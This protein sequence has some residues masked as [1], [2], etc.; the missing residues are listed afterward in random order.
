MKEV[1]ERL[2]I[3]RRLQTQ[4]VTKTHSIRP[5]YFYGGPSVPVPSDEMG[6]QSMETAKLVLDVDLPR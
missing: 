4:L 6:Y 3:L 2:Q 5:H 1:A